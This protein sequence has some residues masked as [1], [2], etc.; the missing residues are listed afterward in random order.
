MQ[1]FR[2]YWAD[3]VEKQRLLKKINYM[4]EGVTSFDRAE[5]V[6]DYQ[7]RHDIIDM[8]LKLK[9]KTLEGRCLQNVYR[10]YHNTAKIALA[11]E[12]LALKHNSV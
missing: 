8:I 5:D 4:V 11:K 2:V 6:A 7:S 3:E 1:R 10:A 12:L 9:G